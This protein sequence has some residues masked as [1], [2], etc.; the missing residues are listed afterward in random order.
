MKPMKERKAKGSLPNTKAV[1]DCMAVATTTEAAQ[2]ALKEF[3]SLLERA[4]VIGQAIYQKAL[5]VFSDFVKHTGLSN[6]G[7]DPWSGKVPPTAFQNLQQGLA[8]E[9]AAKINVEKP[10]KFD[11][12][13]SPASEFQRRAYSEDGTPVDKSTEQAMNDQ[14]L[15]WFASDKNPQSANAADKLQVVS[16]G[17]VLYQHDSKESDQIKKD[18]NGQPVPADAAAVEKVFLD[19]RHGFAQFVQKANSKAQVVVHAIDYA[20][21]RPREPEQ[22]AQI[23]AGG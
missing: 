6:S 19:S 7:G 10:I 23:Q 12:A 3:T 5:S 8:N 15:A 17:G 11:F 20:A 13:I 18:K 14:L 4:G 22:G 16:L 1:N 2:Y 21:Q 9:S